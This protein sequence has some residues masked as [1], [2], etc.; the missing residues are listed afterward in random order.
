MEKPIKVED[1][2]FVSSLGLPMMCPRGEDGCVDNHVHIESVMV[3]RGGEITEIDHTGTSMRAGGASG[4]GV[5][6]EITFSCES[7][8]KWKNSFQFHKGQTFI[9]TTLL[10]H[11]PEGF[12]EADVEAPTLWRD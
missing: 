11:A 10:L 9:S 7:H 12:Y 3:N 2:G 8:H 4:R 6:V 1:L 5:L